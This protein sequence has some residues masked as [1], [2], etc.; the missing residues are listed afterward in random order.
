MCVVGSSQVP[1][2][3]SGPSEGRSLLPGAGSGAELGT[4]MTPDLQ[5]QNQLWAWLLNHLNLISLQAVATGAGTLPAA[6]GSVFHLCLCIWEGL[7]EG[8]NGNCPEVEI[9][10]I[11][12]FNN[13]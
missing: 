9:P 6:S 4:D 10:A 2:P 12:I 7:M 3:S 13:S 11:F 5:A 8:I 1:C